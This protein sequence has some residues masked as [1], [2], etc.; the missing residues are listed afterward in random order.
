MTIR[1]II[2][3]KYWNENKYFAWEIGLFS[4]PKIQIIRSAEYFIESE[5]IL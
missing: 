2:P 5:V 4:G 1:E 3:V